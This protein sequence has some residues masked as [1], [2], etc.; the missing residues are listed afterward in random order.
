MD[1]R[2]GGKGNRISSSTPHPHAHTHIHTAPSSDYQELENETLTIPAGSVQFSQSCG[3]VLVIGDIMEEP[4]EIFNVE[5]T[6]ANDNDV[7]S[8]DSFKVIILENEGET[9]A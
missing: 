6:P 7:I 4:N 8:L 3:S 5:I 1:W 2:D 9:R